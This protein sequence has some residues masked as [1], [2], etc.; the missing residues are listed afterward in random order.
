MG[1]KIMSQ[2][3]TLEYKIMSQEVTLEYKIMSQG[4]TFE[5]HNT[6]KV[7]LLWNTKQRSRGL[8]WNAKVVCKLFV[9]ISEIRHV[10][11]STTT[12]NW[13]FKLAES[14]SG[15]QEQPVSKNLCEVNS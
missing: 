5:V 13:Q 1:Y 4:V 9:Q 3:V 6:I 7:G 11:T 10:C 2:E 12:F 14:K 8:L 15:V